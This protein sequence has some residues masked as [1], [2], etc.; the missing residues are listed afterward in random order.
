MLDLETYCSKCKRNTTMINTSFQRL[1]NYK[2][3]INGNCSICNSNILKGK[4][5]PKPSVNKKFIKM[6][7]KF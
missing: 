7:K 6:K 4:V 3:I 5:I 1:A 2:A